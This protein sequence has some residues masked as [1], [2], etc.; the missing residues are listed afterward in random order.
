MDLSSLD[1]ALEASVYE[2]TY[3]S[4]SHSHFSA[5]QQSSK[6]AS[7]GVRQ[8][9]VDRVYHKVTSL[10]PKSWQEVII[11]AIYNG[12][13]PGNSWKTR[14]LGDARF[15]EDYGSVD[16]GHKVP[17]YMFTDAME[18][19][20]TGYKATQFPGL[21]KV[22]EELSERWFNPEKYPLP[23][24][25]N[26]F[27]H[28]FGSADVVVI[29]LLMNDLTPPDT[30]T[31]KLGKLSM[32][33]ALFNGCSPNGDWTQRTKE[34]ET[35]GTFTPT[36]T[37]KATTCRYRNDTRDALDAH[38]RAPTEPHGDLRP[39]GWSSACGYA[40]KIRNYI[41]KIYDFPSGPPVYYTVKSSYAL[42]SVLAEVCQSLVSDGYAHHL[43]FFMNTFI[44]LS[45]GFQP[46]FRELPTPS[47]PPPIVRSDNSY[48]RETNE[49]ALLRTSKV[50][51]PMPEIFEE[52][53]ARAPPPMPTVPIT[54]YNP[55]NTTTTVTAAASGSLPQAIVVPSGATGTTGANMMTVV[56]AIPM[57]T[58]AASGGANST[59]KRGHSEELANVK[60]VKKEYDTSGTGDD[61]LLGSG[62]FR[63][64]VHRYDG[65]GSSSSD[66]P[67]SDRIYGKMDYTEEFLSKI[68][69]S[70]P[71]APGTYE[72]GFYI[73]NWMNNL[74][75]GHGV[76][77]FPA[78]GPYVPN[79][80]LYT[81]HGML[82]G[83]QCLYEGEFVNG[84]FEGSGKLHLP[85]GRCWDGNWTLGKRTDHI[86][87][88]KIPPR[89]N[90]LIPEYT[91]ETGIWTQDMDEFVSL[92]DYAYTKADKMHAEHTPSGPNQAYVVVQLP[93]YRKLEYPIA[94]FGGGI[95]LRAA[96]SETLTS[97]RQFFNGSDPRLVGF[98]R[99]TTPYAQYNSLTPISVYDIDYNA[100]DI[101]RRH[102]SYLGEKRIP[103]NVKRFKKV[104][105]DDSAMKDL[106]SVDTCTRVNQF[107]KTFT[108]NPF[109]R[110]EPPLMDTQNEQYLFHGGPWS[111]IWGILQTGFD[112]KRAS[113]GMFGKGVY[114]AEDPVKCDQYARG[115]RTASVHAHMTPEEQEQVQRYFDIPDSLLA[116]AVVNNKKQDLFAILLCRVVLGNAIHRGR[117]DFERNESGVKNKKGSDEPLFY[118]DPE[119]KP[120]GQRHL[121][122][123]S[124]S[125]GSA[126]NIS[127]LF[128]SIVGVHGGAVY[129]SLRFREFIVYKGIVAQPT[130]LIFYKRTKKDFP[131]VYTDPYKC[132]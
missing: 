4:V 57:D 53:V 31:Y 59:I 46:S 93:Y 11:D 33:A 124:G 27:I 114:F 67:S 21:Q 118:Q 126:R 7:I 26:G 60:T 52:T 132:S 99:D 37:H 42:K 86:G 9:T 24:W 89:S 85:D 12:N 38:M 109:C 77:R 108:S 22:T 80:T 97:L 36:G 51:N 35:A 68:V 90:T 54:P 40:T 111:A 95:M 121:D 104:I 20:T 75:N 128:N 32:V 61:I 29:M 69:V 3:K 64:T 83:Q 106:L 120:A 16:S 82:Y 102:H 6:N 23:C 62:T 49:D 127:N 44:G 41:E 79:T 101:L 115:R 71:A 30:W 58:S 117:D 119:S 112:E 70:G 76:L 81:L 88:M 116:D 25:P 129:G 94:R 78:V 123:Y 65:A 105:E 1:E 125:M 87:T 56:Q 43:R 122:P 39:I 13:S 130:Q 50:Y 55:S 98:G 84:Y 66:H 5:L 74:W 47:V 100:H 48:I 107:L 91:Y 19:L 34:N 92:T 18:T 110:Y 63:G 131:S 14:E 10:K 8:G 17:N 2:S 72:Q 45:F 113:P 103:D 15:A 28:G 96:P 73:G